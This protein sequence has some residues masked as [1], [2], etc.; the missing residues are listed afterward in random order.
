[1]DGLT[2]GNAQTF[3]AYQIIRLRKGQKADNPISKVVHWSCDPDGV[4][5]KETKSEDVGFD[6]VV[7]LEKTNSSK[8]LK[9]H[10][11]VHIPFYYESGFS[12]PNL[13]EE[14]FVMEGTDEEKAIIRQKLIE[15][16][17]LKEED[18]TEQLSEERKEDDKKLE[19][20]VPSKRGRKP[21]AK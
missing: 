4:V 17:I 14:K 6:V 5:H 8:S 16:G 3:Y 12:L 19:S 2:G 7:K 18:K 13:Q 11:E 1:M 15:K 9:E 10:S 20:K 21:K